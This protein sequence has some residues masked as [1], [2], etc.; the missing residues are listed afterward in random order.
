MRRIVKLEVTLKSG[1]IKVF[2]IDSK[3]PFGVT[4]LSYVFREKETDNVIHIFPISVAM[5]REI[6]EDGG[7][8]DVLSLQL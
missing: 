4:S 8:R 7:K 3:Y 6:F 1:E 5:I 2:N